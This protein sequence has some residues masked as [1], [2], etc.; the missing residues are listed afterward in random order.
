MVRFTK[1]IDRCYVDTDGNSTG[2]SAELK[3][4]LGY[5]KRAFGTMPLAAFAPIHLNSLR[6]RMIADGRVR[7]QIN[8]RACQVRQFFR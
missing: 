2:T 6:E 1:Y 3:I 5:V 7:G 8:K 4:T